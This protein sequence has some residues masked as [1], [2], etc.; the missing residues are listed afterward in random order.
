YNNQ[1]AAFDAP[2]V[3]HPF[4]WGHGGWGAWELAARYS[5]SD[6]NF[7]PGSLGT[8][9]T[10]SSIRGGEEKNFTAG[11]NWYWNSV[12]RVMLDYQNVRIERLSPANTTAAASAIWFTPVGANIGQ[13]FNVWSVRT[14]F[15]F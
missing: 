2:P 1:T 4:S 13:S 14:Q 15:A 5:D 12:A 10:G 8:L 7:D 11:V 3:A 9:Q 6:L